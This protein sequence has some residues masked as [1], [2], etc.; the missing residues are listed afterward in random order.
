MED[1]LEAE[2]ENGSSCNV[3]VKL[4]YCLEALFENGPSCNVHVK[5]NQDLLEAI[6]MLKDD[7]LD[8]IEKQA[9]SL[10]RSP[11]A[12]VKL[13]SCYYTKQHGDLLELNAKTLYDAVMNSYGKVSLFEGLHYYYPSPSDFTMDHARCIAASINPSFSIGFDP[14]GTSEDHPRQKLRHSFNLSLTKS[15]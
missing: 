8:E 2:F 1:C 5:L 12:A 11:P 7:T 4:K 3:R 14:V 10:E 6:T 15:I 9:N 13:S